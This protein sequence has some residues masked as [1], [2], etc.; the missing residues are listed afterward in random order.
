MDYKSFK[1]SL[2]G[3]LV[4]AGKVTL[5]DSEVYGESGHSNVRYAFNSELER[6]EFVKNQSPALLTRA[7][8]QNWGRLMFFNDEGISPS[9]EVESVSLMG[10]DGG[11][12]YRVVVTDNNEYGECK[13]L[14][15][16]AW[17][18]LMN[19]IIQEIIDLG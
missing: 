3:R 5:D 19:N 18:A 1:D 7:S 16:E 2:A 9:S 13:I 12:H 10:S 14:V 6:S 4:T 11:L 15:R 17:R 8:S